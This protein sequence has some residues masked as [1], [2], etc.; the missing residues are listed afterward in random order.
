MYENYDNLWKIEARDYP[1]CLAVVGLGLTAWRPKQAPGYWALVGLGY[2]VVTAAG[3]IKAR[4]DEFERRARW[5]E[6][7]TTAAGEAGVHGA[8]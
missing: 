3:N 7:L 8:E 5:S 2:V 1:L 4:L 6:R